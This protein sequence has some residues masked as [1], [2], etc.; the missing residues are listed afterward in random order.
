DGIVS[1]T[2]QYSRDRR[3]VWVASK[4]KSP[5]TPGAGLG[6][7]VILWPLAET[8]GDEGEPIYELLYL[9]DMIPTA[10]QL[11]FAI[12]QG[13]AKIVHYS[14]TKSIFQPTRTLPGDG[15]WGTSG[16]R[17]VSDGPA[18]VTYTWRGQPVTLKWTGAPLESGDATVADS[19]SKHIGT[20]PAA[21]DG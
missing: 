2:V 13:K 7:P 20:A 10:A 1:G 21:P 17:T 18:T 15:G 8:I 11:A 3:R 6:E 5:P 12:T 16:T 19:A 9:R 14:F 4:W